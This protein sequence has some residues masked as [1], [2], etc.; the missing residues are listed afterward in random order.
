MQITECFEGCA[1][2]VVDQ[3]DSRVVLRMG[4]RPTQK[5]TPQE[6]GDVTILLDHVARFYGI[7]GQVIQ[8]FLGAAK[9]ILPFSRSQTNEFLGNLLA[10]RDHVPGIRILIWHDRPMIP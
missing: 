3:L 9:E 1:E 2:F 8:L 7:A 10:T 4:C 5:L 6:F